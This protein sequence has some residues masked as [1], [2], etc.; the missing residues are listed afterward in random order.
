MQDSGTLTVVIL[1]AIVIL[2]LGIVVRAALASENPPGWVGFIARRKSAGKPTQ[3]K[4][5]KDED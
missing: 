2:V 4:E 5:W 1:G 3:W